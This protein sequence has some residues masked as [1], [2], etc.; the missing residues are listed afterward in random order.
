MRCHI[1]YIPL[2]QGAQK[3][4]SGESAELQRLGTVVTVGKPK[5]KIGL[6]VQIPSGAAE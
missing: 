1:P 4:L 3:G 5:P 6:G 2:R